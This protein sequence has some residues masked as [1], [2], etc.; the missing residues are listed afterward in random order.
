MANTAQAKKRAKQAEESRLHNASLRSA[1]RTCLKKVLKAIQSGDKANAQTAYKEAIPYLDSMV[2]KKI[3]HKN[4][5]S[6]HKSRLNAHIKNL[7]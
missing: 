4:K 5:A 3:I 1:M 6:R 7:P 2:N